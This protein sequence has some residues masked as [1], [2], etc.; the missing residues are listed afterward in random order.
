MVHQMKEECRTASS[1]LNLDE[2]FRELQKMAEDSKF[3]RVGPF[4]VLALDIDQY[5]TSPPE[6]SSQ[7]HDMDMTLKS[8]VSAT[9]DA[10]EAS[11]SNL[12]WDQLDDLVL[13]DPFEEDA[14]MAV[15]TLDVSHPGA[16]DVSGNSLDLNLAD[17]GNPYL[18]DESSLS[19]VT[20]TVL[21]SDS[22]DRG[23]RLIGSHFEFN[24]TEAQTPW[25]LS[26]LESPYSMPRMSNMSNEANLS[27]IP[28]EARMVL[29]YY[30]TC[31]VNV[32][33]ISGG[34]KSPWK[35]IH[36]PCAMN[37][38]AEL[39]VHG[40]A[41][42]L[43][44]MSLFYALLSVSSFHIGL[45]AKDSIERSQYWYERGV[46]HQSQA[47][48]FLKLALGENV[49]KSERGKYKEVLMSLLSMITIGVSLNLLL[50]K[51]I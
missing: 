40:E 33:S 10:L 8:T 16:F 15:Q 47:E 36:F 1:D 6:I 13:W 44:K 46:Y 28:A 43:A 25:Q 29:D 21:Y 5:S 7:G 49:S 2:M 18:V 42:S 20:R 30:S 48:A 19:E 3:A 17:P 51:H 4:G 24:E 38:L 35:T 14:S 45:G 31:M 26:S 22:L 39:L 27:K 32:I 34:Q 50:N 12:A 23:G 11:I 9:D 41:R 37:T